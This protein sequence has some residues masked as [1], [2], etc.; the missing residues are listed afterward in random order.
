MSLNE[1]RRESERM[2][3]RWGKKWPNSK[4]YV[5]VRFDVSLQGTIPRFPDSCC[6]PTRPSSSVFPGHPYPRKSPVIEYCAYIRADGLTRGPWRATERARAGGEGRVRGGR[7]EKKKCRI[8]SPLPRSIA[9]ADGRT[10]GRTVV[11]L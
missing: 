8:G 3:G 5:P 11:G 7:G 2:R 10:D 4:Q 9:D 6:L 1:R